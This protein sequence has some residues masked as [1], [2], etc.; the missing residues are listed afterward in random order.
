[1]AVVAVLT[2]AV[3]GVTFAVV[4]DR[5]KREATQLAAERQL[6]LEQSEKDRQVA[7]ESYRA[8]RES[9]V[10]VADRLPD[11]LRKNLFARQAQ[12]Q[13]M[14]TLRDAGGKQAHIAAAR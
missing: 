6:A 7:D 13:E 3:L 10:G 9:V 2:A 14:A 1:L 5:Q 11:L 8:A 12:Q 4:F